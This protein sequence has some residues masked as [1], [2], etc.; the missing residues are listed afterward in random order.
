[1][2]IRRALRRIVFVLLA[3]CV[4]S[5][6]PEARMS[7]QGG[8]EVSQSGSAT[9]TV[10]I[11]LPPGVAGVRPS[12]AL[13]YDSQGENGLLGVGWSLSGLSVVS[14]CPARAFVFDAAH[15]GVNYDEADRFCLDGQRL[16]PDELSWPL[17]SPDTV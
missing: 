7:V 12:L 6:M 5:A 3:S 15:G 17:L 10:P 11:A 4:F 14:R 13:Q 2:V 9:Y 8:L 1:M 16:I